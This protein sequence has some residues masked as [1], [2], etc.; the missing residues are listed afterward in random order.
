MNKHLIKAQFN[1]QAANFANWS[2]G[3]NIEYLR[4]YVDFCE[5]SPQD[6]LLD[7]ACGPG[8]FTIYAG[9]QILEACGVDISDIEIEIAN[10]QINELGIS[11]VQFDCSDVENLPYKNNSYSLVT[12]KSAF[13]HFSNPEIVLS[14]MKRCCAADGKISIQDIVKYENSNVNDFF[15]TFDKLVDISH[16][17][18]L[19]IPEIKKLFSDNKVEII[20]EFRLD[21]D[22]LI[23]DYIGHAFQEQDK[24]EKIDSL[25]SKGIKDK[26]LKNFLF[27]K[28]KEL[29]FKRPVYL[30]LGLKK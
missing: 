28:E 18:M 23:D 22:L 10:S 15:E 4:A 27:Y 24:K 29:Y 6:K 25:I 20:K 21:V 7:V 16:N 3:K 1:K 8:E 2:V 30:I 17:K 5:I 19:G 11:N 13:H 14:E 26:L 9:Q 12:C